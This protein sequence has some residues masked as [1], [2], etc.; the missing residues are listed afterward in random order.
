M[1]CPACEQDNP[2]RARFCLECGA[3]LR[4]HDPPPSDEE[5]TGPAPGFRDATTISAES[6]TFMEIVRRQRARE[7]A[8]MR[9]ALAVAVAAV[10]V[11][12]VAVVMPWV[13]R[14][15]LPRPGPATLASPTA[16]LPSPPPSSTIPSPPSGP[17]STESPLAEPPPTVPPSN[18]R[19][20]SPDL[21]APPREPRDG[22]ASARGRAPSALPRG[23]ARGGPTIG[24]IGLRINHDPSVPEAQ[25]YLV[26]ITDSAGRPLTDATVTLRG[27]RPDGT[28][29]EAALEASSTP[30][31]YGA[32]LRFPSDAPQE[33]ALRI[34]RGGRTILVPVAE[35]E[36]RS[37]R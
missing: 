35:L 8:R 16:P 34:S 21:P 24:N 32:W 7:R 23:A 12:S 6:R 27:R 37:P 31:H 22:V 1:R 9:L 36:R 4:H 3:A 33:L 15:E 11:A 5:R 26:A 19:P 13:R 20:G 14:A 28:L 10:V 30:G 25:E 17:P 18:E 2:E 29:A